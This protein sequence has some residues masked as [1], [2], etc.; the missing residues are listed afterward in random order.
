MDDSLTCTAPQHAARLDRWLAG[1]W[2][3]F[4]RARWQ[5]AIAAGLVRIN[6]AV[7]RA[8]DPV[9]AGDVI[10]AAPPP[11]AE[12][13]AHAA[14]EDIPLEIIYED[15]D[16]IC[17][18]K[19]PGLVVHPAA[20]HWQGT[21]VNAILDH[22]AQVSQGGNPLRPGIVHRLDKDTSGCIL[23]AKNDTAHAA[24]ARQFAD[25]SAQKTY[26][27]VVRGRPRATGGVVTGA[28]ARHPV[29]RQRMAISRHPGA[30]AAETTWKVLQSADN[31][32]LLECRPKTGRTHQIR[33]HL[34]HLGHPIAGDRV[35]GGG[36]D[37]PRQLLHAWKIA[38]DHPSTGERLAFEAPVPDDFPLRTAGNGP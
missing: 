20:G 1:Q 18:N 10:N 12:P 23:V 13:P 2:P 17:L 32:S 16:L 27:A 7:A 21:L 29:H 38:V 37:F 5:K 22:C 19:P 11:P 36:A 26:L 28:I 15:D 4:S 3:Q 6:G 24:L 9:E 34:K 14:A 30:R 35:Y 25:R 8:S 31:L 33:V